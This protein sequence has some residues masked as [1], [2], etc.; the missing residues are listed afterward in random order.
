MQ[1]RCRKH[2]A[3][4]R[5]SLKSSGADFGTMDNT[6]AAILDWNGEAATLRLS[7]SWVLPQSQAAERAIDAFNND[8]ARK[9]PERLAINLSGLD[10]MDTLGAWLVARI[11]YEW[12]DRFPLTIEGAR[13]EHRF[14]LDEIG[15]SHH[16][17][18]PVMRQSGVVSLLAGI[19]ETVADA[20]RDIIAGISFFGSVCA[21][22]G[23]VL[24][25]PWRFRWT[26]FVNQIEH[27]ALR[28]M[29]I[30][31]L[32]SFLVGGIVAQQ[33]VFQLQTF[34]STAFVAD[35]LGIL[36]LR[37]LAPLLAAVMIAGRSGSAFTAEIGSMKMR[38]EID[39]LRTMGMNPVAVLILPRLLGLVVA[40]PMLTFVSAMA[41]LFGGGLV[42]V[43]Y[44]G[45]SPDVFLGRLQASIGM[46]T[47]STGLIKAPFMALVIGLIACLEGLKVSGSAESLGRHTTAA[48][49]KGIFM[50]IVVDGIFAMFFAAIRF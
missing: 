23:A 35:L 42:A 3:Q 33:S 12:K 9:R 26:A 24:I 15:R 6:P 4:T 8:V 5:R 14:L 38:E 2:C 1:N 48:V 32:I 28:G 40:L 45:V 7:G 13:D 39:A 22:L 41:G 27:I 37:E 34:G 21:A 31:I 10:R 44:G 20:G 19:G 16:A 30:I 46:N 43:Y 29:P 36:V 47:F 11:G 49:V 25:A 18:Q 50:V 17:P